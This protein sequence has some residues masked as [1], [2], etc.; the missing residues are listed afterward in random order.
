VRITLLAVAMALFA[1]VL[2]VFAQAAMQHYQL[3]IPKQPLDT[4]LKDFARQTGLQVARMS[5]A[6]DGSA[7][8]GPISGELSAEE[9]LKS[10]LGPQGL[11]YKMVNE[12]TFAIVKPGAESTSS[13]ALSTSSEEEGTH[14]S[15][16]GEDS[17][18]GSGA[19]EG[20]QSKSFWDRFR[21]AELD[22]RTSANSSATEKDDKLAYNKTPDETTGLPEVVVT[23]QRR[24]ENVDKVPISISVYDQSMMDRQGVRDI[25]DIYQMTPGVDFRDQGPDTQ[26]TIRG[27]SS[28]GGAATAGIY[29]DDVPISAL[30]GGLSSLGSIGPKVFD[31]DRVEVL[32]GPQGTYFGAGAESGAIRFITPQPSLTQSSGYTR[33]GFNGTDN[34]GIGYEAGVAVGGPIVDNELGYRVSAAHQRVGGYIDHYSTIPGGINQ[35]ASNWSDS[36]EVKGALLYQPNEHVKITP[37]IFFQN[38]YKHD[39]SSFDPDLSDRSTGTFVNGGLLGTP[40]KRQIVLPQLKVEL[41]VGDVS[42]TSIS[43]FLY[44]DDT[45]T[46]DY[47][48]VVPEE[49]GLPLPTNAV[50]F[51]STPDNISQNTISQEVRLQNTASD[52]KLK[53]VVG[54]WYSLARQLALQDAVEPNLNNYLIEH[55]G[56]GIVQTL[57]SDL[58]QPG[59]FSFRGIN[60]VHNRQLAGF[61]QIDWQVFNKLTLTA[62]V[63]VA[64][65]SND[66]SLTYEGPLGGGTSVSTGAESEHVT[67][68]KY[69]ISYQ[70]NDTNL[71]YA[72]ASKGNRLGGGNAP[73]FVLPGCLAQLAQLGLPPNPGSYTS[74]FVWNYEI[75]SKSRLFNNRLQ[76]ETSIYHMDW[77]ALQ[78]AVSVPKCATSFTANIG[79]AT[80]DGFD[81]QINAQATDNLRLGL[82]AGYN[83]AR[84]AETTGIPGG[85]VFVNKGD[86]IDPT[87]SPWMVT[88]T[89]EYDFRIFDGRSA[90]A[91]LDDEF[92]SKNPGPFT[93]QNPDSVSYSPLQ[94]VNESQ[95]L[96][97][98]R[99]GTIVHEWDLAVFGANLANAHPLLNVT[100]DSQLAPYGHAY[101]L[102][103]RT[104]G[105][106]ANYRW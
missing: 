101:T 10:L 54:A 29:I 36:D 74:D 23:A 79:R 100:P 37:Q 65:Q 76:I 21:V 5:D 31:L 26:L 82:A 40:D 55:T 103:S 4:A 96:I 57:G 44:R 106:T 3:K 22:E 94:P 50:D 42:L 33:E 9:A 80:S 32:R 49:L 70:L 99:L 18:K 52:T 56:K 1:S 34:G 38:I 72:T 60:P 27:V 68:P 89:L 53:W 92:H 51:T 102:P 93:F 66:F 87:H 28:T 13:S 25:N 6:V 78:Q 84:I 24:V 12:R 88:A 104:I 14:V 61:G 19:K 85:T 90:Y 15:G 8:V 39:L 63:R 95:N 105:V 7:V 81:L 83:N 17:T 75:G 97:N 16:N 43:A 59:N 11:S 47:T 77:L 98:L 69:G 45:Y 91:R 58:L 86:Q 62:G 46:F 41:Q 20:A 48:Q 30:Y 35:A 64:Q 73:F 71:L 2:P 67:T